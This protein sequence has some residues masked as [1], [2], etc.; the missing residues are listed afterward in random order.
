MGFVEQEEREIVIKKNSERRLTVGATPPQVL[1]VGFAA[2]IL[3]GALLLTLPASVRPGGE[4]NFLTSLFTA[5]SAVC[6]TGLVVVDTGTHWTFFGQLVILTLI[7]VGG[8]GFMTMA[9]FFAILMGRR[10]GLR[11]RL[12]MQESLNQTSVSGIVRLAR[13]VLVFTFSAE[14][15]AATILSVRWAA[16]LGWQKGIWY[17]LFHS[18]SA[19]NNA[20]FDLFGEFR[21]LTGYVEDVTVNL[22]ITTLI[23]LGGIGFSVIVDLFRNFRSPGRLSLHTKLTLSVTGILLLAG[24]VLIYCL[25]LSNSLAPL[26]PQGKLLAAYFQ[27]VTPRTAGYNTLNMAALRSAT[28]FLIVVLM[29][30]GASP[31]S[32]GGGIKTTTIGTLAVSIWSMAR[33]RTDSVVFKRRLGQEQ[34]YK[35]LAILFMATTLVITVSLLLSVTESADFLAVLFE[36]TSAF[37][38]VGLTMG[39]TPDLSTAGR[40]LIILTMFLGRVG[41]LTVAFALARPRHKF[42]LRYPEE[43][44]MVG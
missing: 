21:S 42:P 20:G 7:Q 8:L 3:A 4:I 36:T 10:I 37:G 23:I 11:Q 27:A 39:L 16:D 32:T 40:L 22:C 6:V 35:S 29:F 26:S 25:E 28:Q 31:G 41:P 9:T 33:G 14:L 34:V 1:V 19:F 17:G 15:V 2:I 12:I 18:I 13:H 24:T 30:I 38:T 5:T 44:I 43:K